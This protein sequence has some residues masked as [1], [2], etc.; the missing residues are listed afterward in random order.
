MIVNTRE[1][2]SCDGSSPTQELLPDPAVDS[3]QALFYC[4]QT[5]SETI[6]K[7]G[8]DHESSRHLGIIAVGP[9]NFGK[10]IGMKIKMVDTELEMIRLFLK[11]VRE[12]WDPEICTG[13]EVHHSSWGYLLERAEAAYPDRS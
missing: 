8:R 11:K 10:K 4:L 2:S 13:Y 6:E 7:N 3:I 12:D 5:E 9:N 1:V